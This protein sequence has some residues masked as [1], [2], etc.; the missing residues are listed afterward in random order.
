MFGAKKLNIFPMISVIADCASVIA[1][2]ASMLMEFVS[3]FLM[4]LTK[5]IFMKFVSMDSLF[6]FQNIW[7]EKE[8]VWLTFTIFFNI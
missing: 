7:F 5:K 1:D 2:C 8:R 3:I 4:K 6:V